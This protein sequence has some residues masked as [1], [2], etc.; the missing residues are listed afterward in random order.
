MK[1]RTSNIEFYKPPPCRFCGDDEGNLTL[2]KVV[3][4]YSCQAC[5]EWQHSI[6]DSIWQIVG[7]DT[8]EYFVTHDKCGESDGPFATFE[9]AN[10]HLLYLQEEGDPDSAEYYYIEEIKKGD[11]EE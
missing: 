1:M 3:A 11:E 2:S 10:A 9:E 7:Y 5:G 6:L 8:Y 4:D